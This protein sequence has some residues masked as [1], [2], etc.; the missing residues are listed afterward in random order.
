ML[1]QLSGLG[2]TYDV[3][4]PSADISNLIDT[5]DAAETGQGGVDDSDADAGFG[6]PVLSNAWQSPLTSWADLGNANTALE[7]LAA[8]AN[9]ADEAE[10]LVSGRSLARGYLQEIAE[11]ISG[12]LNATDPGPRLQEEDGFVRVSMACRHFVVDAKV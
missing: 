1:R 4:R 9:I 7:L 10:R 6:L 12:L 3:G 11:C 5:L 8:D 2:H